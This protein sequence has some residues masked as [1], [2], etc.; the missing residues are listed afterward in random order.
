MSQKRRDSIQS[1]G[2]ANI[3]G[4]TGRRFR[5]EVMRKAFGSFQR[6][7][8]AERR[9]QGKTWREKIMCFCQQFIIYIMY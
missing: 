7:L 9:L 2:E 3:N 1:A 6:R 4:K 8:N 5:K